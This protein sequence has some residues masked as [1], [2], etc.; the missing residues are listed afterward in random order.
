MSTCSP[1]A[2]V[3]VAAPPPLAGPAATATCTETIG[4]WATA[5]AASRARASLPRAAANAARHSSAVSS[6]SV[7]SDVIA[8]SRTGRPPQELGFR[9]EHQMRHSPAVYQKVAHLPTVAEA[10]DR[11]FGDVR[12]AQQRM[13][14]GPPAL[15]DRLHQLRNLQRRR[16]QALLSG[17][18]HQRLPT[19]PRPAPRSECWSMAG[20]LSVLRHRFIVAARPGH[21]PAKCGPPGRAPILCRSCSRRSALAAGQ[22][23]LAAADS[24]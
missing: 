11:R 21:A 23:A 16:Q 13:V 14:R 3:A 18:V 15:L 12:Q 5:A 6:I 19:R 17:H 1:G 2:T 7:G 10:R 9:L 22:S 4:S 8:W 20:R 24:P